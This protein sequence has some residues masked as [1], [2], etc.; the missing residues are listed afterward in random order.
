MTRKL[1]TAGL[2]KSMQRLIL[3]LAALV[4]MCQGQK[5]PLFVVKPFLAQPPQSEIQLGKLEAFSVSDTDPLMCPTSSK[6]DPHETSIGGLSS[7]SVYQFSAPPKLQNLYARLVVET[8]LC[9]DSTLSPQDR[10]VLQKVLN[11]LKI[12]NARS[13]ASTISLTGDAQGGIK[14]PPII[15][16]GYSYDESKSTYSVQQV[17]KGIVPWQATNA[18]DVQYSYN[19]NTNLSI[20]TQSLFSGIATAIAGAGGATAL[21]SPAAN[22]YLSVGQTV[23]Q[24]VAQSVFTAVNSAGDSYHFDMLQGPDRVMIY[25]FRDL[26]NNP[27]AAVRLTVAFTNSIAMPEPVDPTKDVSQ[28]VPQ[29]TQLQNILSVTVGGPSGG[30][31]LLQEISKESSY[32][33]LLKA[34]DATT[35][36][37]F[38][39]S[40][41]Q[42]ETAL[43]TTYGL[44]SYDTALAMGQILSQ[45][46]TLYLNSDKFYSSGCFRSRSVLKTM[47]I[48]DFEKKPPS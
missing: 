18:F 10:K 34:T 31:T 39:S 40:C 46:N 11:A 3:V 42:L 23:L 7:R 28:N 37:S 1:S 15:P 12:T 29:F 43:E 8:Q 44:N 5:A 45:E 25:R 30:Q 6:P 27:L 32:Q 20:N 4:T 19:A 9:T 33:D 14:Y 2:N 38:Q 13:F 16:F 41:D 21:L 47:G 48:Q 17:G 35:P 36:K 24:D 26:S 22:A